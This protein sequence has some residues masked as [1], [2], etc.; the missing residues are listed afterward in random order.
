M[1]NQPNQFGG[2]PAFGAM[3]GAGMFSAGSAGGGISMGMASAAG[4]IG[5]AP[6]NTGFTSA[7]GFGSTKPA[8]G[9]G[10]D[11]YDFDI[12]LSDVKA[13]EPPKHDPKNFKGKAKGSSF[14]DPDKKG[15]KKSVR[16]GGAETYHYDKESSMNESESM[17]KP[18]SNDDSDEDS[19]DNSDDVENNALS[20]LS[21]KVQDGKLSKGEADLKAKK[22]E[23]D[24]KPTTPI[25]DMIN[26]V[27]NV[28][29]SSSYGGFTE[30][31]SLGK[32]RK[33]EEDDE[34]AD[35][36]KPLPKSSTKRS[37]SSGLNSY[38]E[39]DFDSSNSNNLP[40]AAEVSKAK[41]ESAIKE[42]MDSLDDSAALSREFNYNESLS[43]S[44][45]KSPRM[46][47]KVVHDSPKPETKADPVPPRPESSAIKTE[48]DDL[49]DSHLYSSS[50]SKAKM[51]IEK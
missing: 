4:G 37:A 20:T 12:D 15:D 9:G 6:Q 39:D 29:D 25:Q 18:K 42:S 44:L 38:D 35:V 27:N 51:S 24:K 11:G 50:V 21:Q 16:I 46:P 28:E 41:K 26:K 40:T 47:E 30:S 3:G 45:P 49:E 33:S 14:R 13:I 34:S 17:S 1:F 23:E 7:Y 36:V 19:D 48:T 10:G 31:G 43:H 8:T 22:E 32:P 2:Q 5:G